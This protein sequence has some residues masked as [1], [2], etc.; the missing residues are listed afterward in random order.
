M[1]FQNLLAAANS[2]HCMW[3]QSGIDSENGIA[4]HD[5][6]IGSNAGTSKESWQM[7]Y[8]AECE[9]G[10]TFETEWPAVSISDG[11]D[12]LGLQGA[13]WNY[14]SNF[15]GPLKSTW[16]SGADTVHDG[17]VGMYGKFGTGEYSP[18]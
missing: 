18:Y 8:N 4:T 9:P 10:I 5:K 12:N 15:G 11:A 16:T 2:D 17:G 13:T 14:G 6:G 3:I 1:H 7:H